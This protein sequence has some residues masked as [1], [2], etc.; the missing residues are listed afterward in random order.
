M[1]FSK[2]EEYKVCSL[3]IYRTVVQEKIERR[4]SEKKEEGNVRLY[5]GCVDCKA[6]RENIKEDAWHSRFFIICQ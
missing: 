5:S 4:E 6:E 2:K 3:H 1:Y